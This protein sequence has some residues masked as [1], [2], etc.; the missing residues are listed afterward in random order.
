MIL[1]NHTQY[2]RN[3]LQA[4]FL[5]GLKALGE[6][7]QDI[8]RKRIIVKYSRS[9]G[10]VTGLATL[11]K[12]DRHGSWIQMNLPGPSYP[13]D[14]QEVARVFRHE[15]DHNFGLEHA[16]MMPVNELGH[17]A[18]AEG[19]SIRLLEEPAKPARD[20]QRE[21]YDHAKWML[22]YHRGELA[23]L[24]AIRQR[25]LGVVRRWNEKVEYYEQVFAERK[26]ACKA[27]PD[28]NNSET[29]QGQSSKVEGH[30]C[31]S[32]GETGD[33]AEECAAGE[34]DIVSEEAII[35]E[36]ETGEPEDADI[37]DESMSECG[38]MSEA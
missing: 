3:D 1:E 25:K 15:L 18:W 7:S 29:D 19:L 26:A 21:R 13:L 9:R 5:A 14:L 22:D 23:K 2:R 12:P 10:A 20:I 35:D 32:T 34:N 33:A 27:N 4:F 17:Q 8:D 28:N 16:D 37:A 38:A 6:S 30:D 31:A 11:G 24:E 36:D